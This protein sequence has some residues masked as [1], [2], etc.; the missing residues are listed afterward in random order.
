MTNQPIVAADHLT[1]EQRRLLGGGSGPPSPARAQMWGSQFLL[2]NIPGAAFGPVTPD[3]NFINLQFETPRELVLDWRFEPLQDPLPNIVCKVL[4]GNGRSTILESWAL[5]AAG[6][7][8]MSLRKVV[9][10][11]SLQ[12]AANRIDTGLPDV[13][14][15]LW[16]VPRLAGGMPIVIASSI[17]A[18]GAGVGTVAIP[19]PP[20]EATHVFA[21]A[22]DAA[23]TQIFLRPTQVGSAEQ[24]VPVRAGNA[25]FGP[26]PINPRWTTYRIQRS[27]VIVAETLELQWLR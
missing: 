17:I 20:P 16:A 14:M 3:K 26:T 10:A 21:T 24:R 1:D 7:M 9:V 25:W 6:T 12:V 11:Q 22:Q 2:P 4:I 13:V 23:N 19:P 27:A 5:N 15:H 18:F 8:S